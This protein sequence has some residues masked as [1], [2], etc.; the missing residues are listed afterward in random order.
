MKFSEKPLVEMYPDPGPP[1][2]APGD[3]PEIGEPEWVAYRAR[4]RAVENWVKK[5][6][7]FLVAEA[8][9]QLG[10]DK[11]LTDLPPTERIAV[12]LGI[13]FLDG[14]GL[15]EQKLFGIF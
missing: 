6:R 14:V 15:G 11:S 12:V 7:K 10:G 13:L 2:E 1:P 4:Q 5:K 3:E 8:L 9:D